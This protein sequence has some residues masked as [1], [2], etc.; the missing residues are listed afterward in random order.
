M[1]TDNNSGNLCMKKGGSFQKE[2]FIFLVV[3]GGEDLYPEPPLPPR[4]YATVNNASKTISRS[5]KSLLPQNTTSKT[6][7]FNFIEK[8]KPIGT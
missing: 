4:A 5:S 6:S 8:E 3:N 7:Y 1:T 2:V